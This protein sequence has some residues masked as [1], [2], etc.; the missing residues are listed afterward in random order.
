MGG[1]ADRLPPL[2]DDYAAIRERILEAARGARPGDRER[3]L[4]CG[5]EDF[6]ARVVPSWADCWS[7]ALPSGRDT[8]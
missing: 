8:P 2:A 4:V 5:S 1:L 3:R 7:M 6:T